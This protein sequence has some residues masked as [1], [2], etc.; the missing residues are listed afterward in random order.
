MLNKYILFFFKRKIDKVKTMCSFAINISKINHTLFTNICVNN[1]V[2]S[3]A[4]QK[5][6][7]LLFSLENPFESDHNLQKNINITCTQSLNLQLQSNIK[8]KDGISDKIKTT[9]SNIVPLNYHK[10]S[11]NKTNVQDRGDSLLIKS[12]VRYISPLAIF[13]SKE[14]DNIRDFSFELK[15]YLDMYPNLIKSMSNR[16]RSLRKKIEQF[17]DASP[18][19]NDSAHTDSDYM[20]F[21]SCLLHKNIFVVS[22]RMYKQYTPLLEGTGTNSIVINVTKSSDSILYN[23]L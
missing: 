14:K 15:K 13:N 1:F 6:T 4:L 8:C 10:K 7:D 3:V 20:L 12:F 19:S 17:V 11:Y 23:L 2:Q 16:H 21:W 18:S 22:D 9:V 5:T